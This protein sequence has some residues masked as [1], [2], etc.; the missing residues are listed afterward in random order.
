MLWRFLT[1]IRFSHR[2]KGAVQLK[3]EQSQNEWPL[4]K[5]DI[6][7]YGKRAQVPR[8]HVLMIGATKHK[9]ESFKYSLYT[10]KQ[11]WQQLQ[12]GAT[13]MSLSLVFKKSY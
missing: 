4:I 9:G 13:H 12:S 2:F 11:S 6:N 7:M 3:D 5:E 1:E 8:L 10:P